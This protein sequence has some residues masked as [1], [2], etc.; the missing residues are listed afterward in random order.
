MNLS[1]HKKPLIVFVSIVLLLTTIFIIVRISTTS[2]SNNKYYA[3]TLF[4]GSYVHKINI[5]IPES[6][7]QDLLTNPTEKTKYQANV[8]I[9]DYQINNVSFATK[10][11][12]S[13]TEV[14]TSNSDRYSFKIN[15]G[16]YVKDQTYYGLDK[17]NLNNSMSDTTY[18]KDY[19]SYFIMRDM[20]VE[21]P[22][23]SYAELSINGE[24]YGLYVAVEEVEDSFLARNGNA[25]DSVLY[26]PEKPAR[27]EPTPPTNPTA[28][29][30]KQT[31]PHSNKPTPPEEP[32][33]NAGADLVYID[34]DPASYSDIFDHVVN[35]ATRKDETELI[36]TIKALSDNSNIETYWD[37]DAVINYFAV[38]NFLLNFDSYTGSSMHNYY[39][40]QENGFTTI[41]PW[42]YNLA[43]GTLINNTSN[44]DVT[45]LTRLINWGIDSPLSDVA[46]NQRPLWQ[47][48]AQNP[49]YLQK[50]HNK[51]AELISKSDSYTTEIIRIYSLIRDYVANDPTA[52][53]NVQQFDLGT[54]TLKNFIDLRSQSI[55]KQLSGDIP[56]TNTLQ[57]ND[58]SSLIDGTIVNIEN[59]G[60]QG[61]DGHTCHIHVT[62]KTY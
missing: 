45:Y 59:M 6:S 33:A 44:K 57:D 52:F 60:T 16:K 36:Q 18:M 48:I 22:L 26:K 20:G 12:T 62:A 15:F 49:E 55:T 14:A 4:D 32:A 42:D 35:Q 37:I 39:L 5:E 56:T 51:L 40:L 2:N 41:L 47:I 29:A 58:P 19:L 24:P 17:L 50:Y 3:D 11:T 9:D 54:Q 43:F 27:Q 10:G 34:N 13:L 46:E 7:W 23:A 31:P 21:T 53:F 38:H 8:T 25:A 30:P 61:G 1:K 28:E